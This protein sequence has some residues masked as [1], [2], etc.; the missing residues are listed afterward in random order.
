MA[1][2]TNGTTAT[3]DK[4]ALNGID[5]GAAAEPAAAKDRALNPEL[6]AQITAFKT[7]IQASVGEVVLANLP[8]YRHQT[9]ADLVHLVVEPM[10]PRSHRHRQGLRR[11]QGRGDRRHRDLGQRVGAGR[12]QDPR[13]DPGPRVIASIESV[14]RDDAKR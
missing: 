13:A 10:T 2:T 12:R 7:R 9:L 11:G 5:G 1:K 3:A 8:R 14:D 4:P 6:L